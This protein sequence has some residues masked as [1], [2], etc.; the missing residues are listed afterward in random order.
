[1]RILWVKMGG[2]WPLTSGGRQRSF[3]TLSELSRRH[4]VTV[5]TTHAPDDDGTRLAAELPRCAEVISVPFAAPKQGTLRFAGA[6]AASWLSADP[7]DLRKWTVPRVRRI[8]GDLIARDSFDVIVADFLTAVPNV[9]SGARCPVVL[10]EHNVEYLIWKRLCDIESRWWRRLP[11]ELE[12][13][14]VRRSEVRACQNADLTIAVSDDDGRRL[15]EMAPSARVMSVPTG[16]DVDYFQPDATRQVPNRLVFSGSMDWYPNE[17]AMLHF[18][19]VI[20]PLVRRDIPDASLTIVGR[21]P[22]PKI[23]ALGRQAGIY[24]TG[25]V[26]DV[27]PHI[28][29]APV[30]IVPLRAGGGTRLKI[31]EALAMGKPVVSTTVGAE[32]LAVAPGREI[33]L[34]DD[35]E[36]FSQAVVALLRDPA[37]RESIGAAG[38]RLVEQRYSWASVTTQFERGLL[39]AGAEK[40]RVREPAARRALTQA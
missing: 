40:A 6:L 7:V 32:G 33:V 27:R 16:V 19:D 12:W 36:A 29:A 5:V 31:F 28:A 35:P 2:L 30:Y 39:E 9:T 8:V 14:K 38:R 15:A 3:Q 1:M 11:L 13:R 21:R 22:S 18:V 24:V 23:E 4:H 10:F 34:A 37:R 25:T 17:D 26:D 20:L